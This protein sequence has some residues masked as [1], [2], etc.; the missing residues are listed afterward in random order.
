[1]RPKWNEPKFLWF[2]KMSVL[3]PWGK[4]LAL[5]SHIGRNTQIYAVCAKFQFWSNL[6]FG[7][8]GGGYNS[9]LW[10]YLEWGDFTHNRK[11]FSSG[12]ALIGEPSRRRGKNPRKIQLITCNCLSN[13]IYFPKLMCNIH[14]G[15]LA[16]YCNS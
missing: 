7:F 8:N 14:I 9:Y 13:L 6:Q 16:H 12:R 15:V 1:M 10:D 2:P 3:A 4:N 5:V 11:D